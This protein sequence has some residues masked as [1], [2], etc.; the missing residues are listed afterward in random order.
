MTDTSIGFTTDLFAG[1]TALV[2]GASSGIGA[3]IARQLAACGARVALLAR[4]EQALLQ[5][6]KEITDAGGEAV[7]T[8][9]DMRDGVALDLAVRRCEREL[10]TVDL[11]VH[12]AAHARG[13]VFLCDQS[14]EE[15][16]RTLDINLTGAFRI[17]KRVVPG[18]MER[19]SG[20]IVI[21]S[22]VAGK[23][24]LPAN[25]AYCASKF[26]LLGLTQALA[27]EL[28]VFDIRVNAVCP[29]LT[30]SPGTTDPARYGNDFMASLAR[31]HGPADL[32]WARYLNRAVRSTVLRR[33]VE[34]EEVAHQVLYLLSDLSGGMTGQAID[35]NAGAL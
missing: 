26:G 33:L 28:G 8:P 20:G 30:R 15:W 25:T 7:V 34:P 13:Q 6:R 35:V 31:H 2:A 11:L 17:C 5:V 4:D 27:A 3:V 29:G 12:G 10:G 22:S 21:V 14:E 18:M 19:R 24:G 32:T 1:R 23:R 9:A 16:S